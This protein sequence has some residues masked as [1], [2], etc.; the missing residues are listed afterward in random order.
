MEWYVQ[1]IYVLKK[2]IL[3]GTLKFN[4]THFTTYSAE[5][6]PIVSPPS[7]GGGGGTTVEE[8]VIPEEE[9]NETVSLSPNEIKLSLKQ[10]QLII[11]EF[12]LTNDYKE[13]IEVNIKIQGVNQFIKVNE[14]NFKLSPGEM[15]AVE[16]NFSIA[17]N[18]PSDNYIGKI[19]VQTSKG[20]Y[21]SVIVLDIQS[22]E[23]LFDVSLILEE[24]YAT[25]S[26]GDDLIFRTNIFNIGETEKVNA[27]IKYTIK[28]INGRII[29]EEGEMDEIEKY[30]EKDGK[31]KL[32]RNIPEGVYILSVKVEYE[33]KIAIT[34]A[35][36][37]VYVKRL[38]L[39]WK[40]LMPI[41]V[42]FM[43][44]VILWAIGKKE[45]KNQK[46]KQEERKE[47]LRYIF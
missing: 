47:K 15:K 37:Q 38:P 3:E 35:N 40:L 39:I 12:Y 41:F 16:L 25:L 31:I 21:E 14:T 4:V 43:T 33:G 1:C 46:R 44:L 34:S 17:K 45:I 24:K 22:L 20:I 28:D 19:I 5:E 23:S 11:E 42:I 10:G 30:L 2:V 8:E 9:K 13:E 36:F 7:G 18:T 29:F 32:P 26:P 6:T 27:T